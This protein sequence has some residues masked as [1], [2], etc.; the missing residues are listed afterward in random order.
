MKIPPSVLILLG[1]FIFAQAALASSDEEMKRACIQR[2]QSQYS[3]ILDPAKL[4]LPALQEIEARLTVCFSI[5]RKTRRL[6]DY[7]STS[8]AFLRDLEFRL[9]AC[10]R[11]KK[12]FN[13]LL[14]PEYYTAPALTD[15]EKRLTV[16]SR[17]YQTYGR[18]ANWKDSSLDQLQTA[19]T[20]LASVQAPLPKPPAQP[21]AQSSLAFSSTSPLPRGVESSA[22][23]TDLGY[24]YAA[25]RSSGY[26]SFPAATPVGSSTRS[27]SRSA[28]F[29]PT[30]NYDYT[31]YSYGSLL[32]WANVYG[33]N[34]YCIPQYS[35]PCIN[36]YV[37]CQSTITP[38]ITIYGP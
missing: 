10:E 11:I 5:M 28:R 30:Y 35:Y 33:T 31:G 38:I 27:S 4:T 3:L 34:G 21:L 8:L 1:V 37:P 26:S 15:L 25:P 12:N 29:Y 7:R 6:Y 17:I 36:T 9:E 19:E 24:A 32:R 23:Y 2:L 18:D 16:A 20:Q 22:S 13:I 14:K